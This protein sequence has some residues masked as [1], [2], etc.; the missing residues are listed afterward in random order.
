M[1]HEAEATTKLGDI[2]RYIMRFAFIGECSVYRQTAKLHQNSPP[3]KAFMTRLK[4]FLVSTLSYRV[5]KILAENWQHISLIMMTFATTCYLS[6]A[7]KSS[8]V[9]LGFEPG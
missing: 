3:P 5:N 8:N 4:S 2:E 6:I 1:R 7:I 9:N